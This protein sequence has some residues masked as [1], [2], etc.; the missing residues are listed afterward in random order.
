MGTE[1]PEKDA[2]LKAF[3]G[4]EYCATSQTS[5]LEKIEHAET[6]PPHRVLNDDL[7]MALGQCLAE[8]RTKGRSS[9]QDSQPSRVRRRCPASV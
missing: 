2:E 9:L 8:P 3:M 5:S 4:G 6:P 7:R 1:G